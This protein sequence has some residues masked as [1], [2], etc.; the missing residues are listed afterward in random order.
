MLNIT[1]LNMDARQGWSLL[2]QA[3]LPPSVLF[4]EKELD[5]W[6]YRSRTVALLR[7]YARASVE[8]GRLRPYWGASSFDLELVRDPRVVLKIRWCL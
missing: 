2:G 8:V 6:P 7:R 3:D 1:M 4:A 5:L